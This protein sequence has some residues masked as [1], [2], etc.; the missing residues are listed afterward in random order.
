MSDDEP[1]RP[2]DPQTRET[3]LALGGA[4]A[5]LNRRIE[6]AEGAI[7]AKCQVDTETLEHVH[8]RIDGL[9]RDV[10][11]LDKLLIALGR[12]FGAT[13]ITQGDID[14]EEVRH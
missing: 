5:T 1:P 7:L 12:L 9:A 4:I 10:A 6:A 2:Y 8:E 11:N 14:A 13:P 3:L